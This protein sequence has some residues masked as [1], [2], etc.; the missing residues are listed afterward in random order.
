MERGWRA[1][2][3]VA[4][5][6]ERNTGISVLNALYAQASYRLLFKSIRLL[7]Q[8]RALRTHFLY[9]TTI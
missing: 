9:L 1:R 3:L 8:V 4:R 6:E 7:E 2:P 5:M